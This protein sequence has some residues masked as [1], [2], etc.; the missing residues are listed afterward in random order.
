MMPVLLSAVEGGPTMA[1]L[2]QDLSTVVTNVFT[3]V[4]TIASTITST[5]L[6]LLTTG[7][8]VLGGAIGIFGRLLSR[9]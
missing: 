6:L 2:L 9:N 5:P 3:W 1:S 8:L 4:G 7:F